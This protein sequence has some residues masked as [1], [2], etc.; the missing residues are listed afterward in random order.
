MTRIRRWW[1][2]YAM[3]GILLVA[4]WHSV[5]PVPVSAQSIDELQEELQ[6]KRENLKDAEERIQRFKEELQLKKSEARTLEEQINIIEDNAERLN[7]SIERTSAEIET[8]TVEIAA[9]AEEMKQKE[10]EIR[11]QK[12]LLAE[13]IKNLYLLDQQSTVTIFL[14]YGTFAEAV[15]EVAT[16]T[17]LQDR[18]QETLV[19][20]KQLRDELQQQQT[21]LAEFKTILEQLQQQQGR[22]LLTLEAQ[23]QSKE[24]ILTL[25]RAQEVEFKELLSEAQRAHKESDAEIRRLDTL[26]RE[27]LRKQGVGSLPVVGVFDWPVDPIFGISCGFHCAD[28]PYAYL[29]GPHAGIDIP[30]YAGTPIQAPADGY[31]ARTH[32]AGGSGYSYI[33]LLHGED[34]STVYG[35]VSGFAITEG[36]M[37]TRGTVIGYTGGTPGT[38]GAGLSS[39]PHLHFEVRKNN[40]PINPQAYLP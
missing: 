17:D 27:E 24:A 11:Q 35:H 1:A 5:L 2:A 31:I 38:R 12:A 30:T 21:E 8:T 10:E 14:K 22:Q 39:G 34:I 23:Q 36:Q 29:I 15:T 9:V 19:A 6:R 18:S 25:T 4:G 13:Y 7:L 28:Y 40:A 33:L 16:L 20:I 32:D 3:I 26:I 37:V